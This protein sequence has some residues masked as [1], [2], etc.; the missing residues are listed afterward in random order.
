MLNYEITATVSPKHYIKYENKTYQKC[1]AS[2]QWKYLKLKLQN[3]LDGYE[4]V[5][6]PE[7]HRNLNIHVHGHVMLPENINKIKL[8]DM[9]KELLEMGRSHLIQVHNLQSWLKYIEKDHEELKEIYKTPYY[10]AQLQ[11]EL[12]NTCSQTT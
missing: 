8:V 2:Q 7:F 9:K 10:D 11:L 1:I 6:Y 5:I 4:F 12:Y 3:I